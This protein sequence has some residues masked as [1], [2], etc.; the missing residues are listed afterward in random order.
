MKNY[1]QIPKCSW[2]VIAR[3]S[4]LLPFKMTRDE[5]GAA[6]WGTFYVKGHFEQKTSPTLLLKDPIIDSLM[7]M[8]TR[9]QSCANHHPPSVASLQVR[10]LRT[11]RAREAYLNCVKCVDLDWVITLVA[12][13]W[14]LPQRSPHHFWETFHFRPPLKEEVLWCFICLLQSTSSSS[15]MLHISRCCTYGSIFHAQALRCTILENICQG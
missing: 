15:C 10:G 8:I 4:Y 13:V 5:Q 7:M 2:S 11:R 1:C 14:H 12:K 9:L 6:D 3:W